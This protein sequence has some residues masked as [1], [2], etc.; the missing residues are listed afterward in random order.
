MLERIIEVLE[1]HFF[2]L[3]IIVILAIGCYFGLKHGLRS[4]HKRTMQSKSVIARARNKITHNMVQDMFDIRIMGF[5][6]VGHTIEDLLWDS[7]PRT[8]EELEELRTRNPIAW[9]ET[10][11]YLMPIVLY[12]KQVAKYQPKEVLKNVLGMFKQ[13]A[14]DPKDV[15]EEPPKQEQVETDIQDPPKSIL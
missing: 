6:P 10:I 2:D 13:N 1:P 8:M 5:F 9:R 4:I 14:E 12:L 11:K 3:I 15:D 7:M